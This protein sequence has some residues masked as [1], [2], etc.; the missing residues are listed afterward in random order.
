VIRRA[1]ALANAGDLEWMEV[2]DALAGLQ[3]PA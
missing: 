3:R 1:V 2:L